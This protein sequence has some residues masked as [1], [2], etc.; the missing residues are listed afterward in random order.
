MSALFLGAI[1]IDYQY[2][3]G[4]TGGWDQKGVTVPQIYGLFERRWR[5]QIPAETGYRYVQCSWQCQRSGSLT[6]VKVFPGTLSKD[7]DRDWKETDKMALLLRLYL[8]IQLHGVTWLQ[9]VEVNY[10]YRWSSRGDRN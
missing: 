1:V 4:N 2:N 6:S 3:M 9:K 7:F 8:K 10:Q 5:T